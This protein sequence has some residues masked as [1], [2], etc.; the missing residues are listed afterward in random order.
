[1][2]AVTYFQVASEG[3]RKIVRFPSAPV[4]GDG[5]HA[6]KGFDSAPRNHPALSDDGTLPRAIQEPLWGAPISITNR[7]SRG[8]K[9]LL[10]QFFQFSQ[11]TLIDAQKRTP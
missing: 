11:F 3:H 9:F 4:G 5:H 7:E 8:S 1:V 6:S 10:L 2:N